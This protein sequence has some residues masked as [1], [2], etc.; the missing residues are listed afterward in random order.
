MLGDRGAGILFNIGKQGENLFG[1]TGD[2][3][4]NVACLF[5]CRCQPCIGVLEDENNLPPAS[6][7]AYFILDPP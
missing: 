3:C 1:M 6:C 7:R 2:T 4:L 5:R